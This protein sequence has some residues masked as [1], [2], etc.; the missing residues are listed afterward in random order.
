VGRCRE[1]RKGGWGGLLGWK[2]GK[3]GF[4]FY[5]FLFLILKT[6]KLKQKQATTNDAQALG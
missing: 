3:E 1:K 2:E 4:G 5:F 6:H